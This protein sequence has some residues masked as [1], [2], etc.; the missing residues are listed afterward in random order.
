ME[1][2]IEKEE[3]GFNKLR[4][5]KSEYVQGLWEKHGLGAKTSFELMEPVVNKLLSDPLTFLE[6]AEMVLRRRIS[7]DE[8][9]TQDIMKVL[10]CPPKDRF[11]LMLLIATTEEIIAKLSAGA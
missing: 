5:P 4:D 6:G 7:S 2:K 9:T 1:A 3:A 11:G 10:L 8:K